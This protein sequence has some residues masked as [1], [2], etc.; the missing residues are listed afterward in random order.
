MPADLAGDY[1]V[2]V[3]T[4][5]RGEQPECDESNNVIISDDVLHIET[6][7]PPILSMTNCA[8]DPADAWPGALV[9]VTWTITNAGETPTGPFTVDHAIVLSEDDDP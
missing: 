6:H 9:K 5:A 4:D 1:Y 7:I 3:E 2:I 8:V